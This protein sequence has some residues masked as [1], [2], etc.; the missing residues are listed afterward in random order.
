MKTQTDNKSEIIKTR[1]GGL[2]SSDAKMVISI[3]KK[4]QGIG[5]A[6]ETACNYARTG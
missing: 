2:G 1:T 5:N 3:G 4:R 6:K